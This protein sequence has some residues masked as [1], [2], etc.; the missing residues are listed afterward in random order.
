[1]SV[2]DSLL[3]YH[4]II[5][6]QVSK[7]DIHLVLSELEAVLERNIEGAIVEFGC[8]IG[9][10]SLFIQRLLDLAPIGANRV[11]HVY[12]S[13]AGLPPKTIADASIA[14]EGFR[15]GE[16][17]VS[18]RQFVRE[19]KRAGL[20]LPIMH[21]RWFN[22]LAAADM[23]D[24]VAFAFLDG[25]FYESILSS[26][27]LVWPRMSPGGT[28]LIDDYAHEALPGVERAVRDFF[29]GRGL[30]DIRVQHDIAILTA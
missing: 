11:F 2:P 5:S 29:R 9:T 27:K 15:A 26:L 12:D 16:L 3:A 25:D 23:P 22:E 8:Y 28:L 13:F 17:A 1:M 21:K 4:P 7:E 18:K 20:Q 24:S 19:F 6:N 30:P 10:T 14:G